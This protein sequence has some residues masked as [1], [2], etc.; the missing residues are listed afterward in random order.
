MTPDVILSATAIGDYLTCEKRYLFGHV[1]RV[2]GG[3]SFPA[4]IGS[5]VHAGVEA[6]WK[7]PLRPLE[8]LRRRWAIEVALVP[9]LEEDP[10][11][12][13]ADAEKMLDVYQLKVAPT[14]T[15]PP[16]VEVPFSIVVDGVGVTGTIDAMDDDL[17]DLKTTSG[18]TINGRKPNFDP[19]R[20]DL[21]LGIYEIGYKFL[22]GR[23]P[24]RSLLDVL[25][26]RG[27]Y[28]QYERHPNR[29]ETL[30][31]LGIVRDAIMAESFEPT[32]AAAGACKWCPFQLVC[33]DAV[34]T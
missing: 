3:Q 14:F 25:T 34:V 31:V 6:L 21:Q 5:A 19:S 9:T 33:P 32:G 26:R 12:G 22:V 29:R 2:G 8:A 28:R 4:A 13:L 17:R 30:D 10:A 23:Q 15:S 7:S 20:Y 27:T 1:Y 18:K 24:K 16:K 11:V